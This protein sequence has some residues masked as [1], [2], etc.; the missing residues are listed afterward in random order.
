MN[1]FFEKHFGACLLSAL[2]LIVLGVYS[3]YNLAF[4]ERLLDLFA[5]GILT[6]TIGTAL[7]RRTT[8]VTADT[9]ETPAITTDSIKDSVVN[10]ETITTGLPTDKQEKL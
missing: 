2:F 5:G 1:A 6:A 3:Y 7:S 8:N 9:V 10:T 4:L